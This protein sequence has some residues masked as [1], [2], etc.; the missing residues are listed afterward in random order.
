MVLIRH[1]F[2]WHC[3]P[4]VFFSPN[5]FP[6]S[7]NLFMRKNLNLINIW[8]T[9]QSWGEGA[10][11]RGETHK[12]EIKFWLLMTPQ[13]EVFISR[14][15]SCKDWLWPPT[16]DP[17]SQQRSC[18]GAYPTEQDLLHEGSGACWVHSFEVSLVEVVESWFFKAVWSC[19]LGF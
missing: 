7:T 18:A 12:T 9:Q 11:S 16:T 14:L 1:A 2:Y 3:F 6:L 5:I 4:R 19:P 13:W 17:H 8:I 10:G 15:I